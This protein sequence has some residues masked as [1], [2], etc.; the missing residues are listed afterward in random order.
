MA[1]SKGS[2][3]NPLPESSH[4][5]MN[6]VSQLSAIV[7][8]GGQSSRMG[9]DKALVEIAGQPMLARVCEVAFSC[10][11]WVYVVSAWNHRY[12]PI[13]DDRVTFVQEVSLLKDMHPHGPLVGFAQGL[14]QV[15]TEWV[16]LLACDMPQL[17]TETLYRW[18]QELP[19]LSSDTVA[20]MAR[21]RKGWWEPMC[22]FYRRDCK[23]SLEAFIQSG[24]RS[25]Q[26]WLDSQK[27]QELSI[28]DPAMLF[29]CNTPADVEKAESRK[30]TGKE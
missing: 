20:A 30:G 8:A 28:D 14:Q 5:A 2:I 23:E 3:T 24:G 13:L 25:F 15:K 7:L 1:V 10:T 12:R 16:L 17:E 18:I 19:R 26:R 29:N 4:S 6:A 21:N 27:V 11:P 9:T 22:G